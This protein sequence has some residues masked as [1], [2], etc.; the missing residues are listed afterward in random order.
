MGRQAPY[1]G[2]PGGLCSQFRTARAADLI[3]RPPPTSGYTCAPLIPSLEIAPD[4]RR[5]VSLASLSKKPGRPAK[6]PETGSRAT[7]GHPP[8]RP[9]VSFTTQRFPA[10]VVG[11]QPHRPGSAAQQD[12]APANAR[13]HRTH[14]SARHPDQRPG[15][16]SRG[17]RNGPAT[18]L[19][20]PLEALR[21]PQRVSRSGPL[22]LPGHEMP[23][24]AENGLRSGNRAPRSRAPSPLCAAGRKAWI[25]HLWKGPH[26]HGIRGRLRSRSSPEPRDGLC[27]SPRRARRGEASQPDPAAVG[28]HQASKAPPATRATKP[29]DSGGS[30]MSLTTSSVCSSQAPRVR[31]STLTAPLYR[32]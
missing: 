24:R 12:M 11:G 6:P 2:Q 31:G 7:I 32:V 17:P 20:T 4:A 29:R 3:T 22:P 23:K 28:G 27:P 8:A 19:A 18:A 26:V 25:F 21:G 16:P 13:I 10:P 1:Y 14:R 5:A 15:T 9:E 30:P